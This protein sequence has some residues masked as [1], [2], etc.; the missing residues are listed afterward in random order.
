MR[1]YSLIV[2]AKRERDWRQASDK[3]R[4][5]LIAYCALIPFFSIELLV[6]AELAPH[7]FGLY[8]IFCAVV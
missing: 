6:N 4:G 5:M 7:T 3:S 2:C 1:R 8:S